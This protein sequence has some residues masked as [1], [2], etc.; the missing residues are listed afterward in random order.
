MTQQNSS[1]CLPEIWILESW[2]YSRLQ[3]VHYSQGYLANCCSHQTLTLWNTQSSCHCKLNNVSWIEL[4]QHNL[5]SVFLR[6]TEVVN[7]RVHYPKPLTVQNIDVVSLTSSTGFSRII[8]KLR[9]WC[10]WLLPCCQSSLHCFLAN[11]KNL[12]KAVPTCQSKRP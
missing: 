4:I 7:L 5:C 6:I 11:L 10:C 2:D 9:M 1:I 8:V 12:Q 3:T